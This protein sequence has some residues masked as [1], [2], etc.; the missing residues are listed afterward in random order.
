MMGRLWKKKWVVH[1]EPPIGGPRHVLGYLGRY[2]R[3]VAISDQRLVDYDHTGVT[4]RT[5][6]DSQITIEPEE[7]IRRFLMHILPGGLRKIRHFGLYAP[8]NVNGRLEIARAS[9]LEAGL[10]I[11]PSSTTGTLPDS[12]VDLMSLLTGIHPLLCPKCH[13]AIMVKKPLPYRWADTEAWDTS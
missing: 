6:G 2:I 4:F 8:S 10:D 3:R 7:F 9:I 12:W 13:N 5:R 11:S 1:V